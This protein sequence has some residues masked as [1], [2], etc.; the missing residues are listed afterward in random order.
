MH[1]I[2]VPQVGKQTRPR[3]E[4]ITFQEKRYSAHIF[5]LKNHETQ[6]VFGPECFLGLR[7]TKGTFW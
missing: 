5:Y 3:P 2:K 6:K 1:D 7:K 4:D